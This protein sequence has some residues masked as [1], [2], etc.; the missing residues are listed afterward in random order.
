MWIASKGVRGNK[1]ARPKAVRPSVAKKKVRMQKIMK[2]PKGY[3]WGLNPGPYSHMCALL[4]LGWLYIRLYKSNHKYMIVNKSMAWTSSLT[5]RPA[6]VPASCSS[7]IHLQ[8]CKHESCSKFPHD[9]RNT[10]QLNYRSKTSM[11]FNGPNMNPKYF[12]NFN[13]KIL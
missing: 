8:K 13:L 11:N 4:P 2:N 6:R 12:R 3:H 7:L 5:S 10:K 1:K 9:F